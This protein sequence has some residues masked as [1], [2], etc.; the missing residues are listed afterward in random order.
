[1]RTSS[2]VTSL[3]LPLVVASV[4]FGLACGG[5][6]A[7][8]PAQSA[9]SVASSSAL[10][11]GTDAGDAAP[12][13]A[14]PADAAPPAA[15]P[16]QMAVPGPLAFPCVN[17]STCGTHRCN[18]AYGKCAYPCQ[19]ELDCITGTRCIV[20]PGVVTPGVCGTKP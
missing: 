5:R 20:G 10:G 9:A 7:A 2:A 16:G 12:E 4:A 11:L 17:D 19:T 15:I 1:M 18:T 13:G 3:A 6:E 8:P 14:P